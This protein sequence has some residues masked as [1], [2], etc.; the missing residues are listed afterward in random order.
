MVCRIHTERASRAMQRARAPRRRSPVRGAGSAAAQSR[1][2]SGKL[3]PGALHCV[4]LRGSAERGQLCVGLYIT[5]RMFTVAL[6]R[7]TR[8]TRATNTSPLL[9]RP[10]ENGPVADWTLGLPVALQSSSA[11]HAEEM[12]KR[13]HERRVRSRG[14]RPGAAGAPA[15][16]EPD[17]L[18]HR[19][20][21]VLHRVEARHA[22]F[23]EWHVPLMPGA[24]GTAPLPSPDAA[25]LPQRE[26]RPRPW[27]RLGR[28]AARCRAGSP[29]CPSGGRRW[30]RR[31]AQ[32]GAARGRRRV[33]RAQRRFSLDGT[34][35]LP[36]LVHSCMNGP[37]R[38]ITTPCR[39]YS[40]ALSLLGNRW[41]RR[42]R[43]R[44]RVWGGGQRAIGRASQH[45]LASRPPHPGDSHTRGSSAAR[46]RRRGGRRPWPA[47]AF[48]TAPASAG[49][50][51]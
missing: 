14:V 50:A 13:E 26:D 32:R 10:H 38:R 12:P 48:G 51:P 5:T 1:A 42:S 20:E 16:L 27:P 7:A 45:S 19:L 2:V 29:R 31:A 11:R 4:W 18:Q 39:L 17:A 3:C 6:D 25:R 40:P 8:D 22:W 44:A 23:K 28:Y 34:S 43:A 21:A 33:W 49:R 35:S 41:A 46:G 9:D 37:S 36:S 47:P 15:G 24:R 30:G